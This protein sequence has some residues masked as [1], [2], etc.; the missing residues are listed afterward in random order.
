MRLISISL[1]LAFLAA[2]CAKDPS[3]SVPKAAVGAA[4]QPA[5]E[6]TPTPKPAAKA[7]ADTAAANADQGVALEG[8]ISFLGSKV[9]GSHTG[10]FNSWIGTALIDPAGTLQS[11]SIVVQTKDVEADFEAPSK[12]SKKLEAHLRDDDFFAS[13]KHPTATFQLDTVTPLKSSTG[14]ATH[15]LS[16]RFTIRGTSKA[17]SFPATVE[18]L[19]PF[20]ANAEFSINRKDFGMMYNGKADNLIRDGVVMKINLKAKS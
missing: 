3:Q 11:L 12:W 7:S 5:K 6:T 13:E 14:T 10:R 20:A 8:E 16:G 1:A 18:S 2:G 17:I 19:K 9:T 15:T 4:E